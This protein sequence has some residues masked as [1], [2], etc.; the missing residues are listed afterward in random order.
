MPAGWIAA[1]NAVNEHDRLKYQAQHV[2][3]SYNTDKM[4]VYGELKAY[5]LDSEGWAWIKIFDVQKDGLLAML[6]L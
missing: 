6:S 1:N 2:G 5:F 3:P 4:T